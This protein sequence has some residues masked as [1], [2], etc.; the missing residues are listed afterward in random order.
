[1]LHAYLTNNSRMQHAYSTQRSLLLRACSTDDWRKKTHAGPTICAQHIRRLS[2]HFLHSFV[3]CVTCAA[4]KV[5][6]HRENAWIAH[7][8]RITFD[9]YTMHAWSMRDMRKS[10]VELAQLMRQKW[11]W[12]WACVL[13]RENRFELFKNFGYAWIWKWAGRSQI[14]HSSI[15]LLRSF[16]GYGSYRMQY[17]VSGSKICWFAATYSTT[18]K[19]N[20]IAWK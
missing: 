4:L 16:E 10:F 2:L 17:D 14:K 5:L 8:T 18:K 20:Y 7:E 19:S 15:K 12:G 11:G 6:S 1:M 3:A 9:L 13:V